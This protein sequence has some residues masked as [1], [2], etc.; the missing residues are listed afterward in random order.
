MICIILGLVVVFMDLRFPDALA[1]FL[2]VDV[3]KDY[4]EYYPGKKITLVLSLFKKV[5]FKKYLKEKSS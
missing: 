2:S 4:E 1:T 3:L 5:Y